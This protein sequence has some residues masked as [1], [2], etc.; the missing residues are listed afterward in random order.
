MHIAFQTVV[1]CSV[2]GYA[3]KR[4]AR[5]M[6]KVQRAPHQEAPEVKWLMHYR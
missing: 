4:N 1:G 5:G 2:H 6:T 3:S